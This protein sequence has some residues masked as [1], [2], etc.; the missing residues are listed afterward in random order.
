[1]KAQVQIK[2]YIAGQPEPKRDELLQLHKLM[3]E[4][5][6]KCK[7]WFSDGY[8]A[9]GKLVANPTIGYGELALK[10]ADGKTRE[11]FKIGLSA[12]KT[13]ISIYVLGIKDKKFLP[14]TYGKKIGKATVTGYCIKFKTLQDIHIDVL[15]SAIRE[16]IVH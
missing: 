5:L 12:N 2:K 1:M 7:L 8:D 14:A 16:G 13:G 4:I 6:P 15:S 9:K 3:L 10:Y 11:S